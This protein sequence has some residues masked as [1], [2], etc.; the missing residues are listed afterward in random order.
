MLVTMSRRGTVTIP[1]ALRAEMAGEQSVFEAV[2]RADGVIELHPRLPTGPKPT[3]AGGSSS[4]S[5]KRAGSGE[6][7]TKPPLWL[8]VESEPT[9]PT[10]EQ[11][12]MEREA[13][14]AIAAGLVRRF[15]DA[16]SFVAHLE[17]PTS[18]KA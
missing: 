9:V 7:L 4:A 12:Q 16:E 11:E 17:L 5:S 10:P 18:S 2:R 1:Q 6:R 15:E 3:I 8:L 13:D 14:V